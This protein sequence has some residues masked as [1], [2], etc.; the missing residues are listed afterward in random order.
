M[1]ALDAFRRFSDKNAIHHLFCVAAGLDSAVLGE[2]Q[3]LGQVRNAYFLQ[4]RVVIQNDFPLSVPVGDYGGKTH[5]DRYNPVKVFRIDRGAGT[6]N[7]YGMSAEFTGKNVMIIGA[8]GK[9][10][11]IVLKDALDFQE[12]NILSR[13]DTNCRT[14]YMD[15]IGGTQSFRMRSGMNICRTWTLSSV[16]RQ[17][18]I[19]R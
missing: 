2:D 10:G 13:Q 4:W 15:R 17:A 16:Q 1:A 6:E 7:G 5:E 18:R 9:I 19:T 12:L 3:I 8:S 14:R 11:S